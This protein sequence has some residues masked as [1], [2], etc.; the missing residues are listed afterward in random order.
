M[1]A[2]Y[3]TVLA[4]FSFTQKREAFLKRWGE[5]YSHSQ[6]YVGSRTFYAV[7]SRVKDDNAVL[8]S[9]KWLNHKGSASSYDL[10]G[11]PVLGK[12]C[13]YDECFETRLD[14]STLIATLTIMEG[15]HDGLPVLKGPKERCQWQIQLTEQ[16]VEQEFSGSLNRLLLELLAEDQEEAEA[17][18][19]AAEMREI[20]ER[21][22]IGSEPF[23]K[24]ED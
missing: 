10:Y 11:E 22:Y 20:F 16:Q 9:S 1:D 23:I 14:F 4:D 7:A 12:E 18:R 13:T 6:R 24:S 15:D 8:L 21:T 19:K 5:D 3:D 17:R 2:P